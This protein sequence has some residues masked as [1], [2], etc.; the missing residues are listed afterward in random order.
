MIFVTVPSKM[1][2][3]LFMKVVANP[4]LMKQI[5][6]FQR[7]R[8]WHT[9]VSAAWCVQNGHFSLLKHKRD[10]HY[11]SY[12]MDIAASMGRMDIVV[13]LHENHPNTCTIQAM[14]DAARFGHFSIVQWLHS[15]RSEGCTVLA[16][17]YA[18][19]RNDLE[20]T[21][22]FHRHRTEGHSIDLIVKIAEKG[23]FTM[24][25]WLYYNCYKERSKFTSTDRLKK[26]YYKYF[27]KATLQATK[28][29]ELATLKWFCSIREDEIFQDVL[30]AAAKE[31]SL[32]CFLWVYSE[33]FCL[34]REILT[35]AKRIA[36]HNSSVKIV[37]WMRK[38][39]LLSQFDIGV[40]DF[41]CKLPFTQWYCRNFPFDGSFITKAFF[42]ACDYGKLDVAYW[43]RNNTNIRFFQEKTI[44]HF[45]HFNAVLRAKTPMDVIGSIIIQE[46]LNFLQQLV[47][48]YSL[49]L[50][51]TC[52]KYAL[53][54][55]KLPIAEWIFFRLN[56]YDTK[57]MLK[58]AME[59]GSLKIVEHLYDFDLVEEILRE[60]SY[61]FYFPLLPWLYSKGHTMDRRKLSSYQD[62]SFIQH[63]HTRENIVC[64][65][66]SVEFALSQGNLNFIEW[67]C[68]VTPMSE[69]S[70]LKTSR[71]AYTNGHTFILQWLAEKYNLPSL[72]DKLVTSLIRDGNVRMIEHFFYKTT[73]PYEFIAL[74]AKKR[75][76]FYV[77]AWLYTKENNHP[78]EGR[79][80]YEA[81]QQ[82]IKSLS[83]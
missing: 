40:G 44:I 11:E 41:T 39:E 6:F 71:R 25:Q 31:D 82:W 52:V 76:K 21:Q 50:D 51:D 75:K 13:W 58:I 80:N 23:F 30:F 65:W 27:R 9:I 56:T 14:D 16:M 18:A 54:Q 26:E 37:E 35:V 83:Q 43:L 10:L 61:F 19:L 77:L 45:G 78:L 57:K 73:L 1:D 67:Y 59:M 15:N 32:E 38:K 46:D 55:Q 66:L 34:D 69:E 12:V 60:I 29:N 72:Y 22:W 81:I 48:E 5:T 3:A 53:K 70:I 7:G 24:C 68:S 8:K 79:N 42:H 28:H 64:P 17:N 33:K 74:K 36:I 2:K 4:D 63:Y 62:L 47:E 20:M 49:V